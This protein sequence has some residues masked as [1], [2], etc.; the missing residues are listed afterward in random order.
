MTCRQL[1]RRRLL[2][3]LGTK[4]G[5][6]DKQYCSACKEDEVPFPATRCKECNAIHLR[7]IRCSKSLDEGSL[8]A[9]DNMSKEKKAAFTKEAHGLTREHLRAG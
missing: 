5:P 7:V 6:A 4:L 3:E 8:E 1:A 9:W 2:L